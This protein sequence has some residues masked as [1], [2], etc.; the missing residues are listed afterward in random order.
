MTG[1]EILEA[2][3]IEADGEPESIYPFSPVYLVKRESGD[4]II[5]RTQSLFKHGKQLMTYTRMLKRNGIPIVTPV[6]IEM[7]NP[8]NIGDATYVAYPYIIG[9][10]YT[11]AEREIYEA[12]VLLGKIHALSS[13]VNSYDLIT[14]DVFDFNNQEVET[15][16]QNIE[17]LARKYDVHIN[18]QK[19]K[20]KLLKAVSQQ[21]ELKNSE[22]PWV[23]TPYDYKANNLIYT[24]EPYLIDPDN[25]SWLP[26]IFD[27]ALA[28]LLRA[29]SPVH[30]GGMGHILKRLLRIGNFNGR[31]KSLL[32]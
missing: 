22:L 28:L 25:A 2:F 12:G 17:A 16:V 7:E 23:A 29:K 13:D 4:I 31:G 8:R 24:P 19:L 26:R 11:G 10:T 32:A 18:N 9:D 1:K 6:P 3:G 30:A 21:E 20:E 27:L 5:K 14:Y 15:S